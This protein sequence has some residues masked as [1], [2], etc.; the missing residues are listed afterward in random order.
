MRPC[1]MFV[2]IHTFLYSYV[3]SCIHVCIYMYKYVLRF[4]GCDLNMSQQELE[5]KVRSLRALSSALSN[6]EAS[7]AFEQRSIQT[8]KNMPQGGSHLNQLGSPA[9]P[10]QPVSS[11]SPSYGLVELRTVRASIVC[12]WRDI[13]HWHDC[14]RGAR[15]RVCASMW[16]R[17]MQG[18]V[19]HLSWSR[20]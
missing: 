4:F 18:S 16:A 17:T 9:Q 1:Y 15:S 3:Y 6:Q 14:S 2:C 11:G 7:P 20:D 19:Y 10:Q 13:V 12:W 8:P 5:Y